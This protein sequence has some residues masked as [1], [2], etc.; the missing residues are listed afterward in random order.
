M[1]K[2]VVIESN[3]AS[4]E[5]LRQR[6]ESDV[7]GAHFETRDTGTKTR[8]GA[9]Q[10]VLVAVI[11]AAGPLL[12]ALITAVFQYFTSKKSNR[13]I[14]IESDGVRLEAPAD[15]SARKLKSLITRLERAE[16]TR[17]LLP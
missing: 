1:N 6:L 2:E 15:L 8:D 17:I 11:G 16:K 13:K 3:S 12:G 4:P 5:E 10:T 14:V 7:K 9:S